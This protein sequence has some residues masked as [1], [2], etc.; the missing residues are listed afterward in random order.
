MK[1]STSKIASS[2]CLL[3]LLA[4]PAGLLAQ[5]P[6]GGQPPERGNKNKQ[7]AV[8]EPSTLVMTAVGVALGMGVV[9]IGFRRNR[10]TSAIKTIA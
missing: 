5:P 10:E 1:L 7:V 6:R 2:A 8:P 4:A 9:L 3:A